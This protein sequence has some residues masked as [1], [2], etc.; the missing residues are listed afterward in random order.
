[1]ST[2]RRRRDRA[3]LRPGQRHLHPGGPGC[4]GGRHHVADNAGANR[5]SPATCWGRAPTRPPAPDSTGARIACSIHCNTTATSG[6]AALPN[7]PGAATSTCPT[8]AAPLSASVPTSPFT[9][10]GAGRPYRHAA[11][12]VHRSRGSRPQHPRV[13]A[14]VDC[15]VRKRPERSRAPGLGSRCLLPRSQRQ[16]RE[17][18]SL[19]VQLMRARAAFMWI[20]FLGLSTCCPPALARTCTSAGNG[21][22]SASWH[23]ERRMCRR[24]RGRR[25]GHHFEQQ[26]R[27]GHGQCHCGFAYRRR[28]CQQLHIDLQRRVHADDQ[29]QRHGQRPDCEQHKQAASTFRRAPSSPINGNL[30]LNGGSSATRTATAA[31]GQ[32]CGKQRHGP[33]ASSVSGTAPVDHVSRT[34]NAQRGRR[35]RKRRN[36]HSVDGHGRIQRWRRARA[37]APTLTRP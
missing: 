37:S 35:F 23:V 20:T 3:R 22:W 33:G 6:A 2:I 24:P 26:H 10:D 14:Q 5:R 17:P 31:P 25:H 27:H 21:N 12:L 11:M 9:V 15:H 28:R 8:A 1:M 4:A 36:I 13:S 16:P 29:W 19:R 7:C 34:G 32:Q 18:A 30:T